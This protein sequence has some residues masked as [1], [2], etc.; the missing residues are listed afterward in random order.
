MRLTVL[1]LF[2]RA[3]YQDAGRPGR[4]HCGVPMGGWM[5]DETALVAGALCGNGTNSP[6]V[7]GLGARLVVRAESE[8][9]VAVV[10]A[11]APVGRIWLRADEEVVIEPDRASA[12]WSLAA[13]GGWVCGRVLGSASGQP[14]GHA[15]VAAGPS[16]RLL[17]LKPLALGAPSEVRVVGATWEG[18]LTATLDV[19]SDRAATR[20][21]PSAPPPAIESGS[22]PAVRGTI[23]A[24]PDGR[25][26]VIGP[27]GPTVG[28]YSFVGHVCRA[29]WGR[30]AR[31]P[32]GS[33]VT[34]RSVTPDAALEAWRERQAALNRTLA[35]LASVAG[36]ADTK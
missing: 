31:Q 27:D 22:R 18:L 7:E 10:G 3:S 12:V 24:T 30:L 32:A 20:L 29:D 13:P 21:V 5:D 26:L 9:A 6:V 4:R 34:L 33:Q 19:A 8:G 17:P 28:G 25:L 14:V 11:A 1:S 16:R 15:L 36:V 2:G 23:E 35:Q